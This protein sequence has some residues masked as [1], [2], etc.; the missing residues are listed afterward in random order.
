MNISIKGT[1]CEL[2]NDSRALIE[3]KLAA[4]GKFTGDGPS[5]LSFEIEE[6]IGVVRS[7]AKYRAEGT[8]S[9]D[10]KAFRAEAASDTLEGAV[11]RVRD[12]LARELRGFRGRV[13]DLF[14]RG[15]AR[16]KDWFRFGR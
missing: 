8:L 9:V 5:M 3:K 1:G 4:L 11:D 2:S 7:G 6:S 15:S 16:V 14:C 13:R 12:E 10:G